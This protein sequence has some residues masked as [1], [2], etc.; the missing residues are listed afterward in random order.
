MS[1]LSD[2]LTENGISAEDVVAA[3]KG[4]EGF[5]NAD[6][7]KNV[8]RAAARRAKKS[9]EEAE[10]P[11]L[12]KFGR[13]VTLRTVKEGLSGS[14]LPRIGRKKI[15]RAVNVVLKGKKKDAT[16]L[17][18]LFGDVGARKGKSK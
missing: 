10:T 13:G 11:K 14:P 6:R 15:V 1:N 16:E 8:E 2:F 12:D 9:Y 7:Q 3:S 5:S 18:V 17:P 4:L